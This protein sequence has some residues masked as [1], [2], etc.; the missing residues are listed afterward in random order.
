[1]PGLGA[2][3]L[4]LVR[5]DGSIGHVWRQDDALLTGPDAP[6]NLADVV[7]HIAAVHARRPGLVDLTGGG[8]LL[9]PFG[10]AVVDGFSAERRYLARLVVAVGPLPPTP[11]QTLSQAALIGQRH[12]LE[13]LARSDRAGC[14][15]GAVTALLMDWSAVRPVL[16]AA[17]VRFGLTPDHAGL[18]DLA[19]LATTID[20]VDEGPGFAR[21][22]GFG[23]RQLLLQHRGLWDLLEAR[24]HARRDA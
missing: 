19:A 10:V 8:G 11:G 13:T 23:A 21:A 16:D 18:P 24:A 4:A 2:D 14:A 15:D 17:A 12:A 1:M 7:H 9:Q 6:C 22:V 5:R 3:L 20:T